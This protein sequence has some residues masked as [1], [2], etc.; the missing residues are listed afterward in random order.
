L[1]IPF[2]QWLDQH[3]L[4]E[5]SRLFEIPVTTFGYGNL[6]EIPAP[7]VLR[8]G[9]VLSSLGMLLS[10]F[11]FARLIP[12]PLLL[13]RF[14]HGFGRLWERLAWDLNVRLSV[15][16][17]SIERTPDGIT[18][19]YTHPVQ[20]LNEQ[21]THAEE[22]AEFD[23]LIIACPLV[24]DDMQQIMQLTEEEADLQSRLR[25]IPYTVASYEIADLVLK[26]RVAYHLPLP[27]I[28]EPMIIYQPHVD[29]EL[30]V[31][32]A[33]RPTNEPQ[34]DD[35]QR[36]REHV[37]RYVRAFGGRIREDDDWHSYDAWLY[38]KHVSAEDFR[39]G[40][41]D[42]WE[43]IQG[44]NRT[45]YVGGLFDFD[46]VEGIAHYSRRLVEKHFIG[47]A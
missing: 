12:A 6:D 21:V 7:Y 10:A 15:D 24:R 35:E 41:Y 16:V 45:F 13:K 39:D 29:N 46:Y 18:V 31:F 9:S 28:G 32:Y 11:R 20:L 34:P 26:E 42:R 47:K 23:Y 22:E 43:A 4:G 19:R 8:Y 5:L 36:L 33:R 14:R 1:C 44:D 17:K 27:P 25:F 40:Y 30:M 38:F 37:D 2:T 3:R